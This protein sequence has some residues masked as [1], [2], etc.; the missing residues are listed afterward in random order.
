[1][2]PR[3][4]PHLGHG[5]TLRDEP[6]ADAWRYFAHC[7]RPH[8]VETDAVELFLF[9]IFLIRTFTFTHYVGVGYTYSRV[10]NPYSCYQQ[11]GYRLRPRLGCRVGPLGRT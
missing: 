7:S 8:T 4:V 9:R 3:I 5:V 1:M 10:K 6:G 2:R 11:S